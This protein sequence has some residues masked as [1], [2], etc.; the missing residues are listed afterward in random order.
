MKSFGTALVPMVNANSAVFGEAVSEITV[1]SGLVEQILAGGEALVRYRGGTA[2]VA[3][4][5]PGETVQFQCA[6]RHRGVIRGRLLSVES[7]SPH[8]TTT[9]C[10]LADPI[11]IPCGGC[12]LQSLSVS[13]HPQLKLAWIR[14]HF[15]ALIDD[16]VTVGWLPGAPG[17]GLWQRRRR[18][19]W[20]VA[21][22]PNGEHHIVVGFRPKRSHAVLDSAACCVVT[23]IL[24]ALRSQLQQALEAATLPLTS[25]ITATQLSDGIHILLEGVPPTDG[26]PPFAMLDGDGVEPLPLQWWWQQGERLLPWNRPVHTFHDALPAA[27][28]GAMLLEVGVNDFVQADG[29]ANRAL[30]AW[31]I[32]QAQASR[33]VVDLFCGVGN[34]SLPLA[35]VTRTIVGADSNSNAI[36]CANRSA[37]RL[38][39]RADYRVV[40]L[41]HPFDA[42]PFVGADLLLLDPPRKGARRVVAMMG[43]LLPKR[44]IMMHCDPA[45][46]GRDAT[47]MV[48]QGYRLTSLYALDMFAWSGHVETIS[49]WQ[50][51]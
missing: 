39:L 29:D 49:A 17:A 36:A 18:V 30:V 48:Q 43:Q 35:M 7:A 1:E 22:Q 23:P 13:E 8:R 3:G 41:F 19:H 33:R 21:Q 15:A 27:V 24:G 28:G 45:S 37:K 50:Q 42:A 32:D 10:P 16:G 26:S 14:H 12:A 34:C 44:V 4:A 25:S 11:G 5:L 9:A 20:H 47:A 46:G 2:L 6:A 38:G 40:D 31:L 51:C